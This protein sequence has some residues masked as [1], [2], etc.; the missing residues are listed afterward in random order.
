MER[1]EKFTLIELLVVIA[2][3]AI[4]AGMLLPALNKA[5]AAAQRI[6]CTGNLKQVAL[7]VNQYG[8]DNDDIIL[9]SQIRS[10]NTLYD[11]RGLTGIVG[12]P[13][14]YFIL[15]Y[16]T[17][18]KI[19]SV[20]ASA[21]N[22]TGLT[23]LPLSARRAMTCPAM[24]GRPDSLAMI[25]YGMFKYNIGGHAYTPANIPIMV[26]KFGRVKKAS[27]KGMLCDSQY[28]SP[29]LVSPGDDKIGMEGGADIDNEILQRVS[30]ARHQ[31]TT[32]FAYVDGHVRTWSEQELLHEKAAGIYKSTMFWFN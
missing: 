10:E 9:P 2:I 18:G 1:R 5:R 28:V 25:G 13:W 23:D 31:W 27:S 6:S 15:P 3:I 20:K 32:N 11:N 16:Y 30:R 29:A 4:L 14:S 17:N 12:T 21:P 26:R 22:Y 8:L 24:R 19:P 7:S